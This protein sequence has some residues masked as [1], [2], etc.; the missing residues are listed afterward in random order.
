MDIMTFLGFAIVGGLL[1]AV[2]K[3]IKEKWGINGNKTKLLTDVLAIVVGTVFYWVSNQAWVDSVVGV[4]S[5]SSTV[6]A[7]LIKN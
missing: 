5:A 4:L 6:Y 7:L 3:M 1:S 2:I